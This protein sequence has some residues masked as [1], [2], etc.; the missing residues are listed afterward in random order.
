MIEANCVTESGIVNRKWNPQ[1]GS[2][3]SQDS[4]AFRD[5]DAALLRIAEAAALAGPSDDADWSGVYAAML[6]GHQLIRDL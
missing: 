2:F 5:V 1:M 6:E 4:I 3:T